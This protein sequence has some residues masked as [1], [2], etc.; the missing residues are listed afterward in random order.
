MSATHQLRGGAGGGAALASKVNKGDIVL[1]P[2]DAPY[3]AV[4]DGVADDTA[5]VLA[6]FA[7]ANTKARVGVAA[8]IAH[9]GATVLLNGR[10]NLASLAAP[11][12][13]R[14]NVISAGSEFTIPAA[15]AGTAVLVGHSTS[16]SILQDAQ[17]SLPDVV[18]ATGTSPVA[19]SVGVLVQNLYNSELVCGR[20]GYFETG[21]HFTGLGNGT[22]YNRIHL[23]LVFYC[24][25]SVKLKPLA[26]GWVN[27]NTFVGGGVQQSAGFFGGTRL[28]GYRHLEIDGNNI[29]AVDGNTFL[30]VSFEGDVS[31]H[32][33]WVRHAFNNQWDGCR[34]EAGTA[35]TP[36]AVSGATLT[37]TAHG[38]VVG[39]MII[40]TYTT[41][42]PGGMAAVTPYY[43]VSVPT[44]NTFTISRDKGGT[45]VT[46]SSAGS[47]VIY[48]R[49]HRIY[50]DT[51]YAGV[52]GNTISHPVNPLGW[53]DIVHST[54]VA[55]SNTLETPAYRAANQYA[56]EDLP[57]FRARN[58][59]SAFATIRPLFAAY[60]PTVN[61]LEQPASWA[62]ALS[63]RGV[64]FG[65]A[66]GQVWAPGANAPEGSVAAPAGS[67]YTATSGGAGKTAYVK[68]SG[69]GNTGWAP[70]ATLTGYGADRAFTVAFTG[71]ANEKAD[72]YFTGTQWSAIEVTMVGVFSG[73]NASGVVKALYNVSGSNTGTVYSNTVAVLA[74]QGLLPDHF[75]LSPVTWDA[76][77]SRWKI[78]I[79]H[80]TTSANAVTLH[81][82]WMS[83]ATTYSNNIRDSIG[84]S[85]VYTTDATVYGPNLVNGP[86]TVAATTQA[87]AAYTLALTDAGSVVETTS[88]SAVTVTV[89]PNSS[90]AFPVGTVIELAQYGAGQI[91]VAPGAGV[92]L[93]TAASLTSRTQYST[94]GLRKR[95]TDEWVVSGDLT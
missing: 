92:T 71:A 30:G 4:G 91:T 47:G 23:G 85:A 60:A 36:V 28:T 1:R 94:I 82:R 74:S 18:K 77:N 27:Q 68:E 52:S 88:A 89:P 64:L 10:Y 12:P 29:N 14:C 76:T 24:K 51:S 16:G 84:V 66:S 34:F 38:L 32:C 41:T 67:L 72:L 63:D 3:N 95:A 59:A 7:A 40:P 93:R 13:V 80:R 44:A 73:A 57:F 48:A 2:E 25:V 54:A 26:G 11:V 87:G 79:A 19:G 86:I 9:P 75:A 50:Y 8:T 33:F 43:V 65:G 49:P 22:V 21:V 56:P 35:F 45:A 61:P 37:A 58:A 17:I 70:L 81:V 6:C 83:Q 90:V 62:T 46:F 69:S 5:A 78:T 55:T 31:E 42:L 15:Y 53:L 20:T 39:D